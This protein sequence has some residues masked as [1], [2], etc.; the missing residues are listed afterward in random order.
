MKKF[1]FLLFSFIFLTGC[2]QNLAFVPPAFSIVKTGGIQ[3]ALVTESVNY[4]VKKQTGKNVS[5]HVMHSL[6]EE[7]KIQECKIA[8]SNN[9]QKIF[10]NTIEDL[11][12]KIPQ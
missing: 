8:H 2:A 9:M 1:Y 7:A 4:G 10:F 3:T 12:C 6:N 5:E 11:D